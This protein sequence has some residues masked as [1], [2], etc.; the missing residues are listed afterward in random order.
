MKEA[1][2]AKQRELDEIA[3]EAAAEKMVNEVVEDDD[4]SG[5]V[6]VVPEV[7]GAPLAD[8]PD[9]VKRELELYHKIMGLLVGAS[10]PP[11]EPEVQ[12]VQEYQEVNTADDG[13]FHPIKPCEDEEGEDETSTGKAAEPEVPLSSE[14]VD[15]LDYDA[16]IRE[17]EMLAQQIENET[18][19]KHDKFA[20]YI[21]TQEEAFEG[22]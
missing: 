20:S 17:F 7:G 6:T 19:R 5:V 9:A 3:Q 16:E 4:E 14:P 12:K 1:E 15:E 10:A 8:D 13:L 22:L 2:D 18:S 11:E 21:N